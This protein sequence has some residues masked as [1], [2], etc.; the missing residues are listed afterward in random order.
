MRDFLACRHGEDRGYVSG[1]AIGNTSQLLLWV[2]FAITDHFASC[3]ATRIS[4]FILVISLF[5]RKLK[6]NLCGFLGFND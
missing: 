5:L 6:K 4:N 1:I 3:N 2:V